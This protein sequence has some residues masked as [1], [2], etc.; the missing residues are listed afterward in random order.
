[1]WHRYMYML[2]H[3]LHADIRSGCLYFTTLTNIYVIDSDTMTQLSTLSV[4]RFATG[5]VVVSS[6]LTPI[7]SVNVDNN[8][9]CHV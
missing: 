2:T 7:L 6:D 5:M 9:Y 4:Q 8:M 3:M 1:M